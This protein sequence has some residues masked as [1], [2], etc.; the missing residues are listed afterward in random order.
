MMRPS[1]HLPRAYLRREPEDCRNSMRSFSLLVE[2]ALAT[3]P[4]AETLCVFT[5]RRQR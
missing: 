1:A 4:C 5:N 3:D 2:Q